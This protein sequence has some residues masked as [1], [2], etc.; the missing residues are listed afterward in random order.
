MTKN[1]GG[2]GLL[3]FLDL[4]PDVVLAAAE[5]EMIFLDSVFPLWIGAL[6]WSA[7]K[8]KRLYTSILLPLFNSRKTLP[9]N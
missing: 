3:D 8:K 2:D 6:K 5:G 7:T 9:F 1:G 4:M